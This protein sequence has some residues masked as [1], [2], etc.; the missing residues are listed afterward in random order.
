M[1]G[2]HLNISLDTYRY[3]RAGMAVIIVGLAAAVLVERSTAR[4]FETSISAYYF[5][6]AHSIFIAVLCALGAL[7]IIYRGS[8]DTEDALLTLAGTLAFIVAM[9]PTRRPPDEPANLVCGR[10]DLPGDYHVEH[11]VTNNVWAVVI[12]LFVAQTLTWW[13]Y[14]RTKTAQRPSCGGAIVRVILWTIMGLGL[15]A[16]IFFE[17]EFISLGHGVAA[18]TMFLAIIATVWIN[19][20][21]TGRQ[22]KAK[23]QHKQLYRFAYRLI[24]VTMFVTVLIVVASHLVLREW[25]LVVEALLIVEFTIYWVIQTVELWNT[26]SRITLLPEADQ[27]KLSESWTEGRRND[28]APEA[29]PAAGRTAADKA[30]RAL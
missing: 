28:I 13:Q 29:P 6:S 27:Q 4:C 30:L 2:K 14:R 17:P 19:A 15:V 25:I 1:P 18:V 21:L 10:F 24:A 7:L 12:A 5:T 22:D 8:S 26:H 9:V 16:L 11:G 20:F 23:S 3:L